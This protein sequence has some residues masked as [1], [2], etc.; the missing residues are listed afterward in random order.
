MRDFGLRSALVCGDT[1]LDFEGVHIEGKR[2]VGEHE[3]AMYYTIGQRKGLGIGGIHGE[4]AKGW[5]VVDKDVKKNILYVAS[6]DE[7]SYL[8]SK[9]CTVT[10]LNWISKKPEVNQRLNAK[11]RYRQ[12]DNPII[13]KEI[14]DEQITLE[15]VEPIKAV[16]PGQAA[17]IYDG[18]ICLG[19]GLIDKVIK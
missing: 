1:F 11:F 17:V 2:K 5:F 10:N 14:N 3:G 7:S 12:A 18:D 6:G 8:Y 19:G 4:E 9:G 13:I 16:T 15:F